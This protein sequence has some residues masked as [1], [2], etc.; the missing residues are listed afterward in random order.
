MAKDPRRQTEEVA[1]GVLLD[2]PAFL[3]EIVERM[4]QVLLE[5]EMA[6]HVGAAPLRAHHRAQRAS[7]RPQAP[8]P[9]DAGRYA[10]PAR[11]PG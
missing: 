1:Q 7:Q 10:E 8:H 2:D 5:T 9:E 11:P 6:E 3:R 4:L